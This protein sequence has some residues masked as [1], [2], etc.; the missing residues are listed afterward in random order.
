MKRDK[1]RGCAK[2]GGM[3]ELGIH[4]VTGNLWPRKLVFEFCKTDR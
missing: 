2:D 1:R 3:E 4:K